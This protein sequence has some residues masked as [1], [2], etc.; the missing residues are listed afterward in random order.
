MVKKIL[1][2]TG[3]RADYGIY[4]PVFD[5]IK[6]SKN[7][8]LELIVTGM[9]L[10]PEFGK[11]VDV[12]HQ[13]GFKVI[14]ELNTLTTE[15]TPRAM[16]EY[17]ARTLMEIVKVLSEHR[18]DIFFI[19]GDRGEM[20]AGAIAAAELHIPIAHLHGGELTGHIDDLVRPAITQL[21]Q[22]HLTTAEPHSQNVQTML[23]RSTPHIHTVGAPALD[24]VR[25]L[26]PVPKAELCAE[27]NLDPSL[28]VIL[29]VQHPDTLDAH[30]PEAQLKP[31]L[32]ALEHFEGNVMIVG[33]N[34]DAGGVH[35]NAVLEAFAK[36]QKNRAFVLSLPH[37]RFLSWEAAADVLMGNSSSGII[38]AASFRLPVV[39]IGERQRGRLRS[40]NVLNV[41]YD[42][43]AIEKAL[44]KALHDETFRAEVQVCHNAYG[45]GRSAEKIAQIFEH[46][47]QYAA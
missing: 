15:D 7:L 6:A 44:E 38:E 18:P 2:L 3:T 47:E 20:L 34:A 31:S 11:T 5:A 45:D 30:T 8:S 41:P 9:H 42:R 35:M 23:L 43:A 39:N 17:V 28:P 26:K 33:A 40:G 36:K 10:R 13:D 16:T 25:H 27:M 12:I 22:I 19:L 24:T 46:F 29:F 37:E 32:E 14:A 4:K 21:S 1:A